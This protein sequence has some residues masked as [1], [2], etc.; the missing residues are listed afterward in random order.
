M[1]EDY[2]VKNEKQNK[3]FVV[4]EGT[5]DAKLARLSYKL[6]GKSENYYMLEVELF[7]GRHHQIRCQLAHIGCPIRGDLKYGY[8]RSNP[9][10]SISLHAYKISF[11]HPTT[12]ERIEVVAPMPTVAPWPA[13][14]GLLK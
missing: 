5:K 14:K 6:V 4:K 8:P 10:A 3:S 12:N 13:F 9:D 7:T 11:E 2:L 1:L